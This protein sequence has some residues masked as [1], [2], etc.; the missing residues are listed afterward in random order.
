MLADNSQDVIFRHFF[1]PLPYFDYI[2]PSFLTTTG[3]SPRDLY[4]APHIF[5]EEVIHPDDRDLYKSFFEYADYL[6][7]PM[8]YRWLKKNGDIIWIE[9][10]YVFIKNIDG[11]TIG[12]QA[13][14]RDISERKNNENLQSSL[15]HVLELL[16]SGADLESALTF[17][18]GTI[19][20]YIPTVHCAILVKTE[21]DR[22]D[23]IAAPN[24]PENFCIKNRHIKIDESNCV[25]AKAI[26]NRE[27]IISDKFVE[28]NA[29]KNI[30]DPQGNIVIA[31]T[32]CWSMPIFSKGG[33][34]LGVFNFYSTERRIPS[35]EDEKIVGIAAHLAGLAIENRNYDKQLIKAKLDAEAANKMKSEFLANMSHEIRTP[36]NAII[37]FADLLKEKGLN[38]IK[39]IEY[40][41]RINNASKNLMNIINDILDI[42]KIEAG[43][44][45]I[46]FAPVDIK[47]TL[48]EIENIFHLKAEVK[49]I[50]LASIYRAESDYWLELDESRLRQALINLVGNAIKFTDRGGVEICCETRKIN[51]DFAEMICSVKDS[52]IGI[53]TNQKALIFEPF[54]QSEGQNARK[55]GGTGLGLTITKRL[56]EMMG[57]EIHLNS[58]LGKGS[59]FA[60]VFNNLKI[61]EPQNENTK[62]YNDV[63]YKDIEFQESRILIAEDDPES[64]IV[65]HD[66]LREY[67]FE[68]IEAHNGKELI[69]YAESY[70]PDL[71]I[72]DI[73]MPVMSGDEA[74]RIIKKN[75]TLS[76]IPIIIISA[77]AIR[78]AAEKYAA[79]ADIYLTKPLLKKSLLAA[80]YDTL[81]L[82]SMD[83]KVDT[84]KFSMESILEQAKE[85][86][87][88][89]SV[90]NAHQLEFGLSNKWMTAKQ[91]LMIE[92][93]RKF[94]VDLYEFSKKNNI[95]LLVVY[96]KE[97]ISQIDLFDIESIM[98]YFPIFPELIKNLNKK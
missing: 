10:K 12:I 76:E 78:E 77:I 53:S 31:P 61:C 50:S 11:K 91:S 35:S 84:P 21:N 86:K 89:L 85:Y 92:A 3:F 28:K 1:H 26:K 2:S 95:D 32:S 75:K 68:I 20:N 90:E 7:N 96:S 17:L 23:I 18:A 79:L 93:I 34:V 40:A 87:F 64:R 49:K 19:E 80:L 55:Y 94:A 46:K 70:K 67:P 98:K 15:N 8:T 22:L 42:S 38:P 16:A 72:S 71:I 60:I 82:K 13:I 36:M 59:K 39:A 74:L 41:D 47:K 57:G 54:S 81:P 9:Q 4:V 51:D 29:C 62:N 37:G 97:L 25:C 45:D 24:L 30:K 63:V 27:F 88:N 83:D 58:E 56:V 14:A 69:E 5:I 65:I 33:N 66:Y 73:Q 43:K 52:G 44:L 48:T 6:S